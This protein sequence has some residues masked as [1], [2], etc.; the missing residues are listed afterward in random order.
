M[1][2][3]LPKRAPTLLDSLESRSSENLDIGLFVAQAVQGSV[4]AADK[5]HLLQGHFIP[6][7]QFVFR[8]SANSGR[9][10]FQKSWLRSNKPWLVYSKSDNGGYCLPCVLFAASK[11]PGGQEPGVLVGK[12]L[13]NFKKALETI[14]KH[15]SKPYHVDAVSLA[16]DFLKV[17]TGKQQNVHEQASRGL[18]DRIASNR[19]KL[20]SIMET[21]LLCGRQNIALRGHRDSLTD[22]DSATS[23]GKNLGN[24]WALLQFRVAAGDKALENHLAHA[25]HNAVYT[26]PRIQNEIAAVL[27]DSIRKTILGRVK[28]AK[29]F[30]VIADEVTDISNKEQMSLVLRYVDPAAEV[31]KEDFIDF[32]ECDTGVTG[33]ALSQKIIGRLQA[34]D[35]DLQYL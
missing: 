18:G 32:I 33:E 20:F 17:Q 6:D 10:A 31:I 21:V 25:A 7:E 14:G 30:S 29:F 13:T 12:P 24:F 19:K 22:S 26:S 27:G 34:L 2:E 23:T 1:A 3:P 15:V 35:L 16:D 8:T 4:S 28:T 11:R 9:R 5:Y